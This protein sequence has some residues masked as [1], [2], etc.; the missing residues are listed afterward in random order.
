MSPLCY[1]YPFGQI[2][3]GADRLLSELGFRVTLSCSEKRSVLTSGDPAC[4]FS[5]GRFNRDGRL[6]TAAFMARTEP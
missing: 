3:P 4:L 6:T 2:S 5:L 1:A